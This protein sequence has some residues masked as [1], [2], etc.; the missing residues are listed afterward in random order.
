MQFRCR[1]VKGH[2]KFLALHTLSHHMLSKQESRLPNRCSC[3]LLLRLHLVN[4]IRHTCV[5]NNKNAPHDSDDLHVR[6]NFNFVQTRGLTWSN[7]AWDSTEV[8]TLVT[9]RTLE[10]PLRGITSGN[11]QAINLTEVDVVCDVAPSP[12]SLRPPPLPGK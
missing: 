11:F 7:Q 2:C 5:T 9:G 4:H 6:S 12:P 10:A 3:S 8:L 1:L